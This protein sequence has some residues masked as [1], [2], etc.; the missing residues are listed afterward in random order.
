MFH[1][2]DVQQVKL[3]AGQSQTLARL[4]VLLATGMTN[5]SSVDKTNK[6]WLPYGNVP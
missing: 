6:N 4:D 3:D 2:C 5:I 1:L